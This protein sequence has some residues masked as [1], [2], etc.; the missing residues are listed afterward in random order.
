MLRFIYC[1][2]KFPFFN[3]LFSKERDSLA[4]VASIGD[5]SCCGQR[6]GVVVTKELLRIFYNCWCALAQKGLTLFQLF[7]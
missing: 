2:T 1:Q 3:V 5:D 4:E 7:S 6:A